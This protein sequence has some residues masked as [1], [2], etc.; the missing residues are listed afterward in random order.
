MAS[1]MASGQN[2]PSNDL[3]LAEHLNEDRSVLN[4][5]CFITTATINHNLIFQQTELYINSTKLPLNNSC[6]IIVSWNMDAHL[7]SGRHKS[8]NN[9]NNQN[10]NTHTQN[11]RQAQCHIK[12][13]LSDGQPL[14]KSSNI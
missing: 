7:H 13:G 2:V 12:G 14:E 6:E 8:E 1:G 3:N 10:D 11:M 9:G 4:G 5:I